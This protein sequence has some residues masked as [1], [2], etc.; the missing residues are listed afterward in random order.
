[1]CKFFWHMTLRHW[2]FGFRRFETA[3]SSPLQGSW[4]HE[5]QMPSDAIISHKNWYLIHHRENL[6]T[7]TI[8]WHLATVYKT[9]TVPVTPQHHRSMA[10]H[11][12]LNW[13]I[14]HSA[15]VPGFGSSSWRFLQNVGNIAHCLGAISRKSGLISCAAT[16]T[17]KSATILLI[18]VPFAYLQKDY[19]H[20]TGDDVVSIARYARLLT[21][22]YKIRTEQEHLELSVLGLVRDLINP[23]KTKRICFIY[24]LS[25]YGAVNTLHFGY[26]NQSLNV[27]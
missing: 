21:F 2:V 26:K 23:L 24:G 25:A 20:A 9:F 12:T 1:M 16:K 18:N 27:L 5:D 19:K 15:W 22:A 11:F 13:L 6:K 17:S 3:S 14:E 4:V 7:R 10:D 8:C